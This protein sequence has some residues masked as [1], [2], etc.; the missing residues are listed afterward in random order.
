MSKTEA[1]N[2]CPKNRSDW[3]FW[4]MERHKIEKAVWLEF[5]KKGS[6][7]FNLSW[8]DAVDEAL[9]FGWI[10][11]VKQTVDSE[12]YRQYFTLR[13]PNSMWS[14]VNKDKVEE[15]IKEGQMMPAG[16][17]SIEIA[18]ENCSWS[19]Y[20]DVENLLVPKDL[21]TA[22]ALYSGASDFF[23]AQSKSIRKGMLFW[24]AEA[25]RPETRAR[26]I[27]EIAQLAGQGLKPKQFS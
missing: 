16:F 12:K 10:D 1:K 19:K 15:L 22:L 14:K 20:D 21:E 6:P 18:K 9:C 4:L 8:S 23:C 17:R 3:R 5:Y 24:V 2:F 25:K 11:S 27:S 7:K 13:K 26:R